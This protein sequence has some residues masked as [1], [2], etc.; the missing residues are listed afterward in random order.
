MPA[1]QAPTI[2]TIDQLAAEY[3]E[4]ENQKNE[5]C[6]ALEAK[7]GELTPLVERFGSA[8]GKKSKLLVGARFEIMT[9][10]STSTAVDNAGVE[11]IRRA[12]ARAKATT[13]F[14]KLFRKV[15]RYELAAGSSFIMRATLPAG[16]PRNLRSLFSQAVRVETKPPR[17]SDVRERKT[18]AA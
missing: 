13:L 6:S 3:L 7:A 18:A 14:K 10:T 12:L 11:R 8:H 2:E 9:T 1:D 16:A 4:L 17:L 5:L 15:E